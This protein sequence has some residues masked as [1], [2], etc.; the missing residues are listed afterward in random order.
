MADEG[1]TRDDVEAVISNPERVEIGQ[2]AVEH[3]HVQN[4]FIRV[5]VARSSAPPLVITAHAMYR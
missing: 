3:C 1:L 4:R 2:T 5:I